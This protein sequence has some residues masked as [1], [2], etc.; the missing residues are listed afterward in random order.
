MQRAV[1]GAPRRLIGTY[2]GVT[3]DIIQKGAADAEVELA[4]AGMFA[5]EVDAAAPTGGLH[6]LDE[7]L[8]GALMRLRADGIFKGEF[9]ETIGLAMPR[10]PVKARTVLIIGLGVPERWQPSMMSD[11]VRLAVRETLRREV[12]S[13]SFAPSLLDSGLQPSKLSGIPRSMMKGLTDG[14]KEESPRLLSNWS[15]C[16]GADGFVSQEHALRLALAEISDA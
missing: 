2:R 9:G 3:I 5:H 12:S 6:A 13:V 16:S 15:F 4:V 7:A 11:A 8:S 10:P 1:G 14:L